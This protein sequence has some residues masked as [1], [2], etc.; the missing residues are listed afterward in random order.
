M[1]RLARV[2]GELIDRERPIGFRFEGREYR[3]FAG[4]TIAS[5]LAANG[6]RVLGRSFKYHRRRG[7]L[8]GAGHDVN[9]MMQVRHAGR[10]IPNVRADVVALEDGWDIRAVNTRGGVDADRLAGIGALKRFLPV[11]FYYKAFHSK[12]L[13]PRW[14]RMFRRLA[15]LG[16]LDLGARFPGSPKRYDFCDVLVIGAGPSGLAAAL[17]AAEGG[18]QVLLA[19]ENPVAGGSGLYARA[20]RSAGADRTEALLRAVRTQPRIRLLP[21]TFASGYYADHWVALVSAGFMTKVRARRVVIAQGAFEQPAVFRGNDLPGVMLASAAQ[22]LIY[23]HAVAPATRIAVLTANAQ[24]W[25]A[26]LDAL[27]H[28]IEVAAVLDLRAEPGP[29]SALL[30]QAVAARGVRV[31][32]GA[33]PHEAV[34]ARDGCV[35]AVRCSSGNAAA[36]HI[37]IDGLWMSVGFAP[38]Q[39]LLYQAGARMR[40]AAEIEQFVPLELPTGVYA[41][42]KVNGV[43]GLEARIADGERAG[44]A[45]AAGSPQQPGPA[46]SGPKP[47]AES[48]SHGYPIFAHPKGGEFIDFDEDLTIADIENAC[49]EGFDSSELLKRF[50]T[51][52]MG[53]S[54][55]KHSNLNGLR[56]LA[57]RRGLAPEALGLTTSRPLFH[58]VPLRILA[59]RGFT[60][61]RRTPLDAEHEASGAVWMPAGNWRRPQYYAVAGRSRE[62]SIAAEVLAVRNRAGLIDVGTLGKIEVHGPEAAV[63]LERIYTARYANLKAGMTRYGLMLDEAGVIIDDGV[64]GRLGPESFYFT[65]T[66]GNSATL[67]REFGRLVTQW[68]LNCGLVNLTGHYAAVNL[69][70]PAARHILAQLTGM[71]LDDAAFPYLALREGEIAGVP[72]RV[73]RVGFVGELGYEIHHPA[74]GAVGLWR[75]LMTAGA[76]WQL[77]PFGVEAQRMLRLEKGHLI[78]GQD[79]DGV[80]NALEIGAPWALKMDKPFFVGQRSLRILER[81]G[82]RQTLVG[83]RLSGAVHQPREAHLVIE[84]GAIAGRVTSVGWSPTLEACIGLALVTPAIAAAGR[85]RIRMDGGVMIEAPIVPLPFYDPRGERQRADAVEPGALSLQAARVRAVPPARPVPPA[86]PACSAAEPGILI[87]RPAARARF[88]CKGP[89]AQAWLAAHG[90]APPTAPNS[91]ILDAG[92]MLIARIATGE[93]LIEALEA[94]PSRLEAALRELRSAEGVYPVVRQDLALSIR[95]PRTA[96]LLRQ[97]C[98]VDF[99]PRLADCAA[100]GGPVLLTSMMGVGVTAW[101]R[102]R[103]GQEAEVLLWLDPSFG[104]YFCSSLLEV[105][106]DLGVQLIDRT[107]PQQGVLHA[108]G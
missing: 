18:A 52:G 9:A 107:A 13:F 95:G 30:A 96:E 24:G 82:R 63:F 36:E 22:R 12:R 87:E 48:P 77:Q 54:Q 106:A 60:P 89:R 97:I 84:D 62:E 98:S 64:I 81:Q 104:E 15:G 61:V 25:A 57:R 69:A 78:V 91:A 33:V 93:F 74:D 101:V 43:Y 4:D 73:M 47:G 38:A 19:D 45:A 39:Q 42:G 79:T 7:L 32:R 21:S 35:G 46:V 16:E 23:R 100:P 85:L 68:G 27:A 37:A 8:S 59:G 90:L 6:V 1:R 86:P 70:G 28:G 58:P 105:A 66:T 102:R 67:F 83:F 75:A 40:Y 50:S 108:T 11:G 56:V 20:G 71:A 92:G 53:P 51:L 49:Q 65:T 26:A 44:R 2:P 76:A 94:A 72:C 14:E 29:E 31:L 41:C 99:V 34:P 17:A 55:G 103:A 5:A 80:T 10:S 88:G 3:G